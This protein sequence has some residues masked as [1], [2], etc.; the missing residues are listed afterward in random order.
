V[1]RKRTGAGDVTRHPR[2]VSGG[3]CRGFDVKSW[4][5][6][7]APVFASEAPPIR[8]AGVTHHHPLDPRTI[9][10]APELATLAVLDALLFIVTRVL[11]A[12]H[13]TLIDDYEPAARN[14]EPPTLRE[15]RRV[16]RRIYP[17][18]DAL[19]GYRLAVID[20]LAPS[21]TPSDGDTF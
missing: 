11:V 18:Q 19:V 5:G 20:A 4:T 7:H 3:E 10:E 1:D 15:A 13:P 17:L 16:L 8:I 9:A 12:E 2:S 14:I 21:P 6:C